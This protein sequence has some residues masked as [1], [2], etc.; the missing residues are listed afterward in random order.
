LE[1]AGGD[2]QALGGK[3]PIESRALEGAHRGEGQLGIDRIDRGARGV[4]VGGIPCAAWSAA[5]KARSATKIALRREKE[6]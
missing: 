5:L 2:G 3:E 6:R 1:S 4:P